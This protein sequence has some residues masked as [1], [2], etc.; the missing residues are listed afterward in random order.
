MGLESLAPSLWLAICSI[1]RFCSFD[2][3]IIFKMV[4]TVLPRENSENLE[5]VIYLFFSTQTTRAINEC[6]MVMKK[7]V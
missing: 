5:H 1:G 3:V 7:K 2:D 6:V 4:W